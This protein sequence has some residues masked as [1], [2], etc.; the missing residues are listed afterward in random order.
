MKALRAAA[1]AAALAGCSGAEI[2]PTAVPASLPPTGRE[3]AAPPVAPAPP[4]SAEAARL[5]AL[6]ER[7]RASGRLRTERAPADAPYGPA[8][9]ERNFRRIA[10]YGELPNGPA[11]AGAPVTL[12]KWRG[13]VVW[14][15]GGDGARPSDRVK[16][17]RL[18]AQL[19]PLTGLRF[20]EA[21]GARDAIMEIAVLT[22]AGRR[23][24][25]DR[26]AA[27]G[28]E[29]ERRLVERW[30]AAPTMLCFAATWRDEDVPGAYDRRALIGIRAELP[31]LWRESC[32]DEE[33]AQALGLI[34]DYDRA[35]PSVFNDDEEFAFL[36]TH[37]EA[38]LRLLY[39]PRLR[40]GMTEAEAVP[41]LR[42]ILA[43]GAGG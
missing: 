29:E 27:Q 40:P 5:A 18:A 3:I 28:R 17:T 33:V 23:A 31:D 14:H 1:L 36:T 8:E 43:E 37:D 24:L 20:E 9:L 12:G 32:F 21:P 42:R 25:R 6:Q 15:V 26:Y 35:R 34:N 22:D 10:F 13:T 19:A 2:G 39:D 7:L 30:I 41:I 4:A 38:L 11:P 16:M